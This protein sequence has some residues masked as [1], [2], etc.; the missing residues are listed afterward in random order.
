MVARAAAPKRAERPPRLTTMSSA[1]SAGSIG[2]K[3]APLPSRI[4]DD[5]LMVTGPSTRTTEFLP[6][7]SECR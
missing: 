2:P 4:V 7:M 1:P 6:G 5:T 3:D